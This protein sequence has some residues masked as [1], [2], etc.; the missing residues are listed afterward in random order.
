MCASV[1]FRIAVSCSQPYLGTWPQL[2]SIMQQLNK[3]QEELLAAR[4]LANTKA[5]EAQYANDRASS[6][7]R[8]AARLQADLD[9]ARAGLSRTQEK[10]LE[11][12]TAL[13]DASAQKEAL[14]ARATTAEA[15]IEGARAASTAAEAAAAAA[16]DRRSDAVVKAAQADGERL[17]AEKMLKALQASCAPLMMCGTH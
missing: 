17:A 3:A 15:D 5:A 12:H 6:A 4:T 9:A 7:I 16:E 13:T 8:E 11:A 2:C 10:L 14:R 1:S